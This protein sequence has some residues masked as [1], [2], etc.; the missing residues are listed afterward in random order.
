MF[1]KKYFGF[2]FSVFLCFFWGFIMN[3]SW[4]VEGKYLPAIGPFFGLY[5]GFW[6]NVYMAGKMPAVSAESFST[7]GKLYLDVREVPHI[8][9]DDLK[10]AYFIQGYVHAMHR[11]WQMDFST[12]AAEGRV[13]E[14]VGPLALDFDKNK[15]RKGLAESARLSIETWKKFPE[16]FSLV[17]AYS[18]GVNQYIRELDPSEY[19]VEYKI[20]GFS[21]ELWSPFR[22]ALFHKSMSEVLCGRDKDIELTN[23]R[24]FFG[25]DFDLLFPEEN[26]LMDPVIPAQTEWAFSSDSIRD[27]SPGNFGWKDTGIGYIPWQREQGESGLGSNNWAVAASK[28]ASGNPILCNDPHLTLTLP[29][30]WYEQQ[31]MT[32]DVN[33]YGVT[34]PGIPGVIIGF[35]E[36]VAWGVTNGGWDVMDWYKIQWRDSSQT[37]YLLDGK[38]EKT[39][40]RIETL[41]VR[42][43]EPV[44]DTI[45][46]T[47]WGPVV[48]DDPMHYKYGLA[49]HWVIRYGSQ[50]C[51]LDM[52]RE[53]NSAKNFQ[54]YRNAIRKFPYPAQNIAFISREGDIALTV[55]G[56]MPIKSKGQGRFVLDGAESKNAWNGFLPYEWNPFTH[57]PER[58]F[59]SSANQKS[60]DSSFPVYY[61]DGDFREYRGAILNR[62]LQSR[63]DWTIQD[64][65]DLQFNSYSLKAETAL[66]L[67]LAC[68]DTLS[69]KKNR[70]FLNSL[71]EWNFH[72]DSAAIQPVVFDL[73]FDYLH[74]LVW[75][76]ITLDT[77]RKAISVP[78]DQTT[79]HLMK[80]SAN[81]TYYDLVSTS[82]KE[83]LADLIS[84]AYDSMEIFLG[85]DELKNLNWGRYKSASI[86][87]L[88][89]IP[90]FGLSNLSSSGTKDVL[91]AHART[92]G[93]SWRMAVELTEDGPVAYGIYPGGQDGRPGAKNY[94]SMITSWREG[95]YYEL[96]YLKNGNDPRIQQ[97]KSF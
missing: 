43:C 30:I 64:L 90:G 81:L 60:T 50:F 88:A 2:C 4:K 65:R 54:D 47:H 34:F 56:A 85:N 24:L 9:A 33:V 76:E 8:V 55:Q 1:M 37:E 35:N 67:M 14:I 45:R 91:N 15:R 59:V 96:L 49:M 18:D 93:P 29:S 7:H 25:K 16:T 79:I 86:P 26:D 21:P 5:E 84:I 62:F 68:T 89:K 72:Y 66:P 69:D 80:N 92:F 46:V 44:F 20:M 22:S 27:L 36:S 48:Y 73:W 78:S 38:W 63:N 70:P 57:N 74:K 75:D 39:E 3:H 94:K 87:H 41:Q 95:K 19:P 61:N 71:R 52:F 51:E 11:L 17:E 28:S 97:L 13:S 77:T 42:G 10:R 23:A 32:P 6:K 58:G 12:R 40:F 83:N 53:M 82:Q 31:I